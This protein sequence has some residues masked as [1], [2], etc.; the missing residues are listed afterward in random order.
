MPDFEDLKRE[1]ES[2]SEQVDEGL[3]KVAAE[4]DKV[5]DGRDHGLIDKAAGEAEQQLGGQ[6][7]GGAGAAPPS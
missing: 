5:A 1:A 4:G 3:N 2:H 7:Q 6:Q